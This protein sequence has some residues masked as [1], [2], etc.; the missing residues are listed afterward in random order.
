V[1]PEASTIPNISP[2]AMK[3]LTFLRMAKIPYEIDTGDPFGGKG[4][5]PW[6]SHRGNN[7]ADS[8][9]IIQY[10]IKTFDV[11]LTS[12]CAPEDLA[13]ATAVRIM[14][15]EHLLWG[16]A[17]ERVVFGSSDNFVRVF[18]IPKCI[19]WILRRIA[20]GRAKDQ[21]IGHHSQDEIIEIISKD[22]KTISLILAKK[23]F[24]CG[25]EPCPE[26]AGIFGML[27][28][29]YWGLPNNPYEKLLN[30]SCINLKSYCNR[31]RATYWP[32]WEDQF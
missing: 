14:V 2:F 22:I 4:K 6:I 25:T 18:K 7:I 9:F 27:S 17:M 15:D 10:L 12:H 13:I 21:G 26:D 28:Q 29:F 19:V 1:P 11:D 31:I 24:I 30:A 5:T 32:D 3:V 16:M 20:K 8:E 23:Q